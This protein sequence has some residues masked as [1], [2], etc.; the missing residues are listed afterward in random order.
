MSV[1]N[2]PERSLE[3]QGKN[4]AVQEMI[5]ALMAKHG[6]RI[7]DQMESNPSLSLNQVALTVVLHTTMTSEKHGKQQEVVLTTQLSHTGKQAKSL[8]RIK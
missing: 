7:L 2:T 8:E 1:T 3:W 4:Q 5:T 6:K